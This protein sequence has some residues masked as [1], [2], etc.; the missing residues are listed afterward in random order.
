MAGRF[1]RW[2][3]TEHWLI[4]AS[5]ARVSLGLLALYYYGLHFSV[6]HYLYGPDGVWPLSRYLPG[7]APFSLFRYAPADA[8]EALYG[9]AI[10]VAALFTLGVYPRLMTALHWLFVWSFQ[11]RNPFLGDGGDNFV[12]IVLLFLVLVNTGAYLTVMPPRPRRLVETKA[13]IHNVGVLLVLAQLAYLYVSTGF[14]KVMGE[15]WQNGTA[16]YYILRV[17]EFTW[18]AL[19]R[20]ITHNPWLIV[21]GTYG[22]VLFEVFFLPALLNR[23]TRYLVIAVGI[24]FHVN[25]AVIMGLVTFAWSMLSVYPL[26]L[27]DDEYRGVV[28]RWRLEV[29]YD[30]WCPSCVRSITLLRSLGSGLVR[31]VSFRTAPGIDQDRAVRR[32]LSRRHDGVVREGMDVLIQI[33]ARSPCL[34]GFLPLLVF[35][36]LVFGQRLYD[37]LARRRLVIVPG[38][39]D[40][41]CPTDRTTVR[42]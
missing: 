7:A 40:E 33:T 36:R 19:A 34:W 6:R 9:G 21:G 8:F 3:T 23:Y 2:F 11:D 38:G 32:I 15:V 4:G 28:R 14:Y 18:P 20:Y 22:T 16:L 31:Y 26:L 25:I 10:L 1:L 41:H 17:E 30:G 35:S 37:T 5:L 29:L 24:L 13:I 42:S 39:C 12:R 27:T